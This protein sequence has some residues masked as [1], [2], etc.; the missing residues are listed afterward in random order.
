MFSSVL[1]SRVLCRDRNLSLQ[2]TTDGGLALRGL[3]ADLLL[4]M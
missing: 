3:V 1:E 4:F 2:C